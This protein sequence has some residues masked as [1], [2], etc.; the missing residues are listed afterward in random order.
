MA[1]AQADIT[2]SEPTWQPQVVVVQFEAGT[3]IAAGAAKTGLQVFDSRAALYQVHQITRAFPFLDYVQPTRKT[4][5]NLEAL[6]RTYYVRY[7]ADVEPLRVA[8]MLGATKGVVYA[9]PVAAN[10]LIDSEVRNI[11]DPNDALFSDQTHLNSMRLPEAWDNVK[12]MDGNPPVVIAI[13]DGGADWQHEDLVANVWTNPNEIADNGIDDDNNGFIDDVHGI[14]LANGDDQDNDPTGL[15]ATP[16]NTDHGT[17][18]AGAASAVT[19][20]GTGIAGAAWNAQLMHINAGCQTS[21]RFICYGYEGLLYAAANGADVINASWGG[22]GTSQHSFQVVDLATDMG[23]L[24]V[25]SAGNGSS[26]IDY[27][28]AYPAFHPRVLSVGATQKDTGIKSATSNYG[29]TVNVFAPG[30]S[31]NVTVPDD[32]YETWSGTSLASPLVAG[33]AALVKTKFPGI[34]ADALREQVRMASENMDAENP[35]YVGQLGRGFVN[36]SAS[37]QTPSLPSVRVKD[38]SWEDSD[39]DGSIASGDQVT[40]TVKFV[41]YLSSAQQLT[42]G[43]IAEE[44]YPFIDMT[45]SEVQVGS[46]SSGGSTEVSFAFTVASDAPL[47]RSL[48]FFTRISDGALEDTPDLLTMDINNSLDSVH[49]SLSAVYEATDGDNWHDNTNWDVSSVPT[50]EELEQWYGVSLQGGIFEGLILASNN[51]SGSLPGEIGDL[52]SLERLLLPFN[53]LTGGIPSELGNASQLWSLWLDDNSL[54]GEI[55]AELG[56]LSELKLLWL[57]ENSLSGE[58]PAEL[59]V[60]SQLESLTLAKNSLSGSI[61]AEL[62]NLSQLELL[63]LHENSLTG[64]IP[65]ELGDL[66][67]LELLWLHENSLTGEIPA[68]LGTLTQLQSLRLSRNSLSG[69][70]PTEL[71]GLSR[72]ELLGLGA[73]LL[74]GEIPAELGDLQQLKGLGLAANSLSGEIPKELGNLSQLEAL[75]LSNNLLTGEIPGELGNLSQLTYLS[76]RNN[77]FTGKLPRSF[78]QLT[79]LNEFYF[80]G[81]SLCAPEDAA[82]Q[83]WL[84]SVPN[85]NGAVCGGVHFSATVDDQTYERS[86]PIADLVLPEATGG[87][88]PYSYSLAPAPPAGL[89]FDPGTRTLSG[90]PTD[91]TTQTLYTYKVT[92]ASAAS[93][94]LLFTIEVTGGVHFSITVDDQTYERGIP[95]ADLVLPEATGGTSPY[96]YS[97]APAPPAGLSFDPGTRTLSGTPTDATVQTTY[98]YKV[99]DAS[100]ASASLQFTIEVTGGVHFSIAIDDQTYERDVPIA[101]LVLPE[102]TGGTS[103]YSY[104]LAPAPPAGLSFDPGTR[105][106]SGTPTDATVQTTYTYKVTDASAASA[107]LQFTI[108]VTGGVHFSIAIDDQ[109]YERDV[110]IADLVL[111]EATGGTSPYSYTLAPAPPAGLSFDPGTRT[112]S[113]MPTDAT[114]QTTYTYKVTD[115]SAASA[116]LQFTI[117]VIGGV[118][119]SMT[120][121]DQTYERGVPIA[122]L[123][124]PEAAGGTSPYSYTL[125]PVPPAGLSFDPGTRT[126]SGTPTEVTA[127]S[128]YTYKVTDAA[129]VSDSLQFTI[130]VIAGVRFSLTVDDQT[131]QRGV[132]IADLVLPEATGGTSPY[133]YTLAPVPPAGLSFDPGTRTL[134]GTPSVVTAQSTYTYKVTDGSSVSDSLQF[135]IEVIAGVRFSLTVDDQ[136]Y[137]RGV[138]IADLVLPEAT[139]GT[140]PY[141]YTLAPVPP[142][143]LSFDPGTRTLSG[144]PSVVTAQSTYTYKVTDGSSVSDSLQFTIE[145]V[146]GVHFSMTVDDQTYERDAPIADLIL[147]EATGGTSPYS[148]TLAPA[149]PAGLSFDP[150][151]RTLSG[152]PSVVTAQSTYTYKVTD[153]SS[154]SD[155]LQFAIEVISPTSREG[156]NEMPSELALHGNYPNPFSG[157][158]VLLFDLEE[159]AE[160]AV[161]VMD[162]LGRV[163]LELPAVHL[164]GG[165]GHRLA[166]SGA[167][168]LPAGAYAYRLVARTVRGEV[169]SSGTLLRVK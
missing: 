126:L 167:A 135:T 112:L 139:G 77:A 150:G 147:P 76:L 15:P 8:K 39:G 125:A 71:G 17:A 122:D 82:F 30:V 90:T 51:L 121:D 128:A 102:A 46:L 61:P 129:S 28:P 63:W 16:N 80:E 101:D 3:H 72:L 141:S 108:E 29:R 107:S 113:G 32:K 124:L 43:L 105:T 155:S 50:L 168:A 35:S 52:S 49:A 86:V 47:Y 40:I 165:K 140:S 55:P 18:V 59:G 60:L 166:L 143:G 88:S 100:A 36:A 85:W 160:V 153:A 9:E 12:G 57:D 159:P 154:E 158:T 132:P 96:S 109:T 87:T 78:M 144:T 98:T 110:P 74:S 81:Q 134:S 14:N 26:N 13:V 48:R 65:A 97:L 83:V 4:A 138:P 146:A 25:T 103:P 164:A 116:S 169:V 130:E 73:N 6:R 162:M 117:E 93:D 66:S 106:L 151:T 27:S 20:N 137:Q 5:R 67:H 156:L 37:V 1:H 31:I 23:A 24:V 119:F 99:T 145:V 127:Q 161:T 53:S 115:A 44:T 148:Y 33:V 21:D 19:D 38:W 58:I 118:H 62:G 89:S 114:V 45:E 41:N 120:V 94:S 22:S 111:P 56:S 10:R 84:S 11:N 91:A 75:V 157:S 131:Y 34:G 104:T 69:E 79:N 7:S 68:E 133:S 95:I 123:V 42:V 149:P 70:I 163:V 2:S 152:T 136:T 64:E 92:D 54:S 142:A